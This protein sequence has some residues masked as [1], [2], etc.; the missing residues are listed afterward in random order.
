MLHLLSHPAV[1]SPPRAAARRHDGGVKVFAAVRHIHITL[2][3]PRPVLTRF[4]PKYL[5][6]A[7]MARQMD[8]L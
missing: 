8:H 4:E 1:A 3:E 7:R 6:G 2:P 5:E